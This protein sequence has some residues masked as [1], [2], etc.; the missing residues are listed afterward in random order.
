M[1]LRI[2]IC[3]LQSGVGTTRGYWQ[4]LTTAWKYFLPRGSTPVRKALRFLQDE[5]IDVAAF[6]EI[7]GG[8][9]RTRG[10]DQVRKISEGTDLVH[11]VFFPTLVLGVRVNQGNA[12]CSKFPVRFVENH[13]LSGVGEPRFL[14]EAE[15]EVAGGSVRLFVTHLSL[16]RKIREPQIHDIAEVVAGGDVPTILAGDFNVTT[17]AE[18]DLLR[19]TNLEMAASAPTFPSW[20]PSRGLDYLFFSDHFSVR[21]TRVF[22]RFLF[23]DHL[24][25]LAEVRMVN[26]E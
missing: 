12:V 24:P 3:N 4:Y 25:F 21:E 13:A 22:D 14:S 16:N 11:N 7:E 23:S 18:L 2:A 19:D 15:L 6:C 26:V 9:R 20:K 17:E 1:N 5:Q 8:S 10:I